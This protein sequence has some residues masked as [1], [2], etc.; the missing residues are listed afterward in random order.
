MPRR[1]FVLAALMAGLVAGAALVLL[2]RYRRPA[3]AFRY[4]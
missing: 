3:A 1:A 2:R 4:E